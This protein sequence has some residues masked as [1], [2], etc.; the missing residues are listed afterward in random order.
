MGR[1][2]IVKGEAFER[3][4]ARLLSDATGLRYRR[5]L[6]ETRD[7]NLGDVDADGSP[8]VVQCKVG[9]APSPWRAQ[10]EAVEAADNEGAGRVPLA[11]VR[12]NG[13]GSRPA[14]DL[15]VLRLDDLLAILA[16]SGE[17]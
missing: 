2:S 10:R 7:G 1:R 4:C 11:L 5:V 6:T 17:R 16:S 13:S 14:V 3:E 9:A 8:Y 15:A 12:R